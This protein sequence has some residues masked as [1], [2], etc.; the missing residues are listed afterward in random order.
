VRST[1]TWSTAYFH[2][3]TLA[4]VPGTARTHEDG[5]ANF[6]DADTGDLYCMS[7]PKR[8]RTDACYSL[9]RAAEGSL[10]HVEVFWMRRVGAFIVE[11]PNAYPR[12]DAPA[13]TLS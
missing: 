7:G 3:R 10:R 8:D 11:D 4:R 12:A 2:D 1:K 5:D 9:S 6:Y 13:Q